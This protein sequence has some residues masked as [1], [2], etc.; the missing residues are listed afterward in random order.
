MVVEKIV[1]NVQSSE[2]WTI[3]ADDSIARSK[4]K[5]TAICIRYV[6]QDKET[7][8]YALKM[9]PAA[10]VDLLSNI[11][12]VLHLGDDSEEELVM[13]GANIAKVFLNIAWSTR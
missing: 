11:R 10:I 6:I 7:G 5:L 2:F 4:K 12:K 13:S 3:L 9:D 8:E 1:Q